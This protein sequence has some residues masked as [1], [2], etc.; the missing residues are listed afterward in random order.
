MYIS[1]SIH[2]NV[3]RYHTIQKSTVQLQYTLHT[4]SS[5]IAR[6]APRLSR[7][8]MTVAWSWNTALII[9]VLPSYTIVVIKRNSII[10]V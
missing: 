6:L 8:S 7:S 10:D 1:T 9:A 3:Q 5:R 4:L 2:N